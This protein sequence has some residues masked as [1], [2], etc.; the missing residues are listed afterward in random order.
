MGPQLPFRWRTR[1]GKRKRAGRKPQHAGRPNAPHRTRP[2]HAAA[3]PVHV[4]LRARAGL[5]A[6]RDVGLFREMREAIREARF[7]PAVGDAFR[8]I[9]FSIQNDHAHFII[10]ASD[11]DVLS[12]GMRGLAIRLARAVNRALGIRGPVWGDRYHARALKTPS[13]VRIG[14]VYVLMNAR[15]HGL[16]LASGVDPFSS[17]PWFSGFAAPAEK[18]V[19]PAPTV[20]SGTWLGYA[21]WRRHGLIGLDERPRAPI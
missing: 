1:G 16:R 11:R 21:G 3:H 7:S 8:V 12:R 20:S 10:E 18:S 14:I 9:E 5:P 13:M 2:R 17:A 19:A 15:K 6:L 4:T